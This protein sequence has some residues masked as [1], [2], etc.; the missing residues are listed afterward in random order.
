[1]NE[2]F[3]DRKSEHDCFSRVSEE[4]SEVIKAMSKGHRFGFASFNPNMPPELQT[5]NAFDACMEITDVMSAWKDSVPFLFE[6]MTNPERL[7]VTEKIESEANR[8][9]NFVI[10]FGFGKLQEAC[11]ERNKQ[12]T[13]GQWTVSDCITEHDEE[14]GE[15]CGAIKRL[16]RY[17]IGA[18]T[19]EKT[20]EDLMQKIKDEIGDVQI[21]IANLA[22]ELQLDLGECTRQKFNKTSDK[23]G[24][25]VK[26]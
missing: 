14:W 22:N 3:I 5:T 2:E 1:M 7:A 13:N 9:V 25:D 17:A 4:A 24:F 10:G 23:Y 15:L 18:K 8:K 16:R 11:A 20:T 12:W 6:Y 19:D 21:T 26:V